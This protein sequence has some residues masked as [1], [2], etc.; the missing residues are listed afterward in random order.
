IHRDIKPGNILLESPTGRVKLTDFG[1]ARVADDVKLTRT[2]FVSG[3]PMYM[4]PE[5]TMGEGADRRSDLFS[6]GAILCE[7]AADVPRFAGGTDRRAE[8]ERW[9]GVVGGVRSQK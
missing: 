9:H 7:M 2:G 3:T 8:C 6:L 1:L 5:Q 4:S